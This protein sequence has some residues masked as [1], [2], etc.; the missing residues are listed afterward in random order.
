MTYEAMEVVLDYLSD[1]QRGQDYASKHNQPPLWSKLAQ[2][3]LQ[4]QQTLPAVD[5]F[6]R[7]KDPSHYLAVISAAEHGNN[8]DALLRFLPMAREITK[9]QHI[10][11]AYCY[12]LAKLGKN[13]DI[14]QFLQTPNSCDAQ[15]VG[16]RCFGD[17][18]YEAAKLL[19]VSV[20]N[21][22][23]IASCLV[24]L[25]E[26]G[27][28]IE[29]AK[30]ANTPRTWKD[31]CTACVSAKEYKLAATAGMHI[32]VH[33]DHLEELITYYEVNGV[34]EEMISLLETG[35]GLERVHVGIFTELGVLYAKY[36]PEKLTGHCRAHLQSMNIPKLLRV[37][38]KYG[39]WAEAV[40]LH[41]S[42]NDA[43]KAVFLM[44][45]HSPTC[46]E[47]ESFVQLLNKVSNSDLH[48]RAIQFYLE[49]QPHQLNDLLKGIA[50]KVDL[51]RTV[52]LMKRS[53]YIAL[54]APFL[55]VAQSANSREVNEALNEIFLQE[56]DYPSLRESINRYDN[57]DQLALAKAT[58]RHPRLEFRRISA[59]LFRKL[60]RFEESIS[61]SRQDKEFKD[62][63][64]TARESQ[65]MALVEE[66]LR[67]FVAE[68][69]K[70]M[71]AA[72]LFTCF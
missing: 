49:E 6:I 66:V 32:I 50:K 2:A 53:G 41:S 45:E 57:F 19:F 8:Y 10:D 20:K 15:R 35:I 13:A 29:A 40:F 46:F 70:E 33:P 71:F 60:G 61:L 69:H 42:Y 65:K 56:C 5:C 23:K 21:N 62:V 28:A 52:Q 58:E 59:L 1:L 16:D 27:A 39:L 63:I 72:T 55:K 9:D 37:C 51:V 26:F 17:K 12:A 64:D 48:Y 3:Y 67:G 7:A 38:E 43:D 11:N 54:V 22:A 36:R 25:G 47:H 34:A 30:K 24:F 14:D 44:M 68:G 4:S 31:L 18:L